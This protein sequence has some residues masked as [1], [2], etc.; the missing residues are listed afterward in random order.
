MISRSLA[1]AL[2]ALNL[3]SI[4]S[5]A[6]DSDQC[7][8]LTSQTAHNASAT[9][10]IPALRLEY[11]GTGTEDFRI[12]NETDFQWQLSS[13]IQPRQP[14]DSTPSENDT[15]TVIWLDTNRSD[16]ERLGSTMRLCHNVVPLQFQSNLTWARAA[17]EAS[18]QDSGDCRSL[19]SEACLKR[20]KSQ[21]ETQANEQRREYTA[22]TGSN[23]TV[24]WECM[25]S[26]MVEPFSRGEISSPT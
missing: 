10:T 16:T 19:V 26:G 5:F 6:Q 20:L 24:P 4:P 1:R 13:Y 22:C 15:Q 23:N 21:Y 9:L 12:Y 25:D 14:A 11:L 2:V 3:L 7:A 18:V 8:A 17:L